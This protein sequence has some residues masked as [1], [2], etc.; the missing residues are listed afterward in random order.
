MVCTFLSILNQKSLIEF[1][2]EPHEGVLHKALLCRAR[3][4]C[5]LSCMSIEH[6]ANALSSGSCFHC[7]RNKGISRLACYSRSPVIWFG[8]TDAYVFSAAIHTAAMDMLGGSGIESQCRK[9]DIIADAAYSIFKKP[10]TFTGNFIIDENIL[11]EEGIK[12]FDAYAIK[13]GNAYCF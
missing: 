6:L 1:C 13:P 3:E 12:N 7:L 10:K 11:K 4:M 9:V 8:V 2:C 5:L